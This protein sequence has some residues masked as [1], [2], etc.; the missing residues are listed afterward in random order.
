MKQ[1]TQF[2]SQRVL[3]VFILLVTATSTTAQVF[4]NGQGPVFSDMIDITCANNIFN[5]FKINIFF[6]EDQIN[7]SNEFVIE[8]SGPD[9]DFSNPIEVSTPQSFTSSPAERIP[10]SLPED[11][12]GENYRV[13]IRST[14]PVAISSP[15]IEFAAYFLTHNIPFSINNVPDTI[16]FCPGTSVILEVDDINFFGGPS[17]KE[18]PNLTYNWFRITPTTTE[19]IAT[20]SGPTLE[21]DEEG[22]YFAV[23]NYGSCIPSSESMSNE[24]DVLIADS[25]NNEPANATITSSLGNP[26][27]SDGTGTILSTN[28]GDTYEWFLNDQPI[29]GETESSIQATQSGTYAVIITTGSC[30]AVGSIELENLGGTSTIDVPAV[31]FIE[32][33]TPV[34]ATVTTTLENPQFEW[35]LN[36]ELIDGA[37]ENVFTTTAIGSYRVVITPS[38]QCTSITEL[39]FELSALVDVD[40]I[41]NTI[42]PNGDG[43]NDIWMI[44]AQYVS[45]TNT[46][47]TIISSSGETVLQTNDYANN[48][49]EDID[50]LGGG[51]QVF[52]YTIESQTEDMIVGSIT[53]LK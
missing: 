50:A 11:A 9:G 52:Y 22:T 1:I 17:P 20:N 33:G 25:G 39:F 12:A 5:E 19:E 48:W 29:E 31:S 4:N 41:P 47:V 34:T 30:V 7:S 53:V 6:N 43:I 40:N 27:C 26:F 46:E 38:G 8:L 44:P 18:F 24:V 14:D 28:A 10:F 3:F 37:T 16:T 2:F 35:F 42:S 45:G 23:T 32:I 51:N 15:S 13:R 36:G 49:P 21:V